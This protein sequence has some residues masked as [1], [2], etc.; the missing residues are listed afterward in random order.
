MIRR[1]I[2]VNEGIIAAY[3]HCLIV[4]RYRKAEDFPMKL[5]LSVD[6]PEKSNQ[7]SQS[8]SLAKSVLSVG[9]VE[10]RRSTFHFGSEE[11]ETCVVRGSVLR[12]LVQSSAYQR[13][14]FL[15]M[16]R[17]ESSSMDADTIVRLRT[18]TTTPGSIDPARIDG[19]IEN[20]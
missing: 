1:I 5:L 12:L 9:N 8:D 10:C 4:V 6:K 14:K 13:P 2:P 17:A 18:M 11:W 7:T 19:L 16:L 15:Q 3:S 20:A